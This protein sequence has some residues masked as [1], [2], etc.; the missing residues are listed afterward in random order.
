MD[1]VASGRRTSLSWENT[2]RSALE[3]LA[4]TDE[5]LAKTDPV[6]MNLLVAKGVPRLAHL[7][8]ATYQRQADEI[9]EGVRTSIACEA[10]VDS[11]L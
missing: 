1:V 10:S 4:L 8:I 9:A 5:E 6:A 11:L 2:M 7:D 3:L